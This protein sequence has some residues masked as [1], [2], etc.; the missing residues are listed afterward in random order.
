MTTTK[1]VLEAIDIKIEETEKE[2]ERLR[3]AAEQ[4]PKVESD[5][6][7]LKRTRAMFTGE[8][9]AEVLATTAVKVARNGSIGS[10][11]AEVLTEVGHP[12]KV[13][14]IFEKFKAKGGTA[15]FATVTSTLIRLMKSGKF[16]RTGT[17]TYALQ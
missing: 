1:P 14:E 17:S 3:R 6:N 15:T 2:Y 12:L 13:H 7:A 10:V 4:L 11:L 8:I 5:L 9:K 16:K